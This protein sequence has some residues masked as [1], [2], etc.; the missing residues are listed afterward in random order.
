[1]IPGCNHPIGPLSLADL[2]GNDKPLRV[3]EGLCGKLGD[4]VPA[5]TVIAK[6]C[7]GGKSRKKM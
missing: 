1:M 6:A 2:I 5:G 7:P 3:M 4:K